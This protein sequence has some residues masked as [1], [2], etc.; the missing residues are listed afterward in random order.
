MADWQELQAE[1]A[2]WALHNFGVQ[3]AW[4][5]QLGLIEEVGEFL[6]VVTSADL[7]LASIARRRDDMAD[8]LGD[9]CIYALNLAH[10]AG[11]AFR[12]QVATDSNQSQLLTGHELLGALALGCHAVLKHA[13]GIRGMDD[14]RRADHL[15]ISLGMW[16]RWAQAQC[17][18]F[19]LPPL[20]DITNG[21]WAE[22][23]RRDWRR[24]PQTAADLARR[25]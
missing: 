21:I 8:A 14:T 24:N 12:E 2:A 4:Q 16:Y 15:V 22:V 25:A 11:V 20:L 3:G 23:R 9:Q 1:I 7:N 17:D 13:Q 18:T 10:I 19:G 5:P 6:A